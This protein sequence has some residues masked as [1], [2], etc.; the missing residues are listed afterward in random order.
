MKKAVMTRAW[1]IFRTLIGDR[2]AKLSMA[3]TQ[4]WSEVNTPAVVDF[5]K[6][7]EKLGYTD[8]LI[9]EWKK[10]NHNRLYIK[11]KKNG[12]VGY[13][14]LGYIELNTKEIYSRKNHMDI[15]YVL[16]D[17]QNAGVLATEK[18]LSVAM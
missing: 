1:E 11:D 16:E 2:T 3:L 8:V 15:R 10:E 14:Q 9:Q 7:I 6:E 12:Y 4:A 5:Q 13:R 17:L 18:Y